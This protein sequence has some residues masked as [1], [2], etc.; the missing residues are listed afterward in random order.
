MKLYSM[1]TQSQKILKDNWFLS[2]IQDDFDI[3][4]KMFDRGADNQQEKVYGS[5]E[6]NKMMFQKAELIIEAIKENWNNVFIY[7]DIDVQFFKPFKK[8]IVKLI[9]NYDIRF[10]KDSPYGTTCA[11]FFVCKGNEKT[12]K[13][14]THVKK[15][16]EEISFSKDDQAVLNDLMFNSSNKVPEFIRNLKRSIG[17]RI[18]LSNK[19][20]NYLHTLTAPLLPNSYNVKWG[21]L[22]IEFYSGGSLTGELWKPG[23]ELSI[24]KKIILHHANWTIS[25]ENKIV[26]LKYVRDKVLD[27]LHPSQVL[28]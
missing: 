18:K 6:F 15:I 27:S 12:L 22:P 3:R 11:G 26:Q 25:L 13:I 14:F 10:Q 24:P 23:M 21:Y 28:S 7:S 20:R 4:I 16:L 19:L 2:T 5:L 8:Y 1:C 9:R 17:N